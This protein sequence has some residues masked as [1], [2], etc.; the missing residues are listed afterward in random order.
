MPCGS[1][2]LKAHSRV[3]LRSFHS[4][5]RHDG[6]A[7]KVKPVA[8]LQ[9]DKKQIMARWTALEW[10]VVALVVLY[11]TCTPQQVPRSVTH[12]DFMDMLYI[13][14]QKHA[15]GAPVLVGTSPAHAR[16]ASKPPTKTTT[17]C[18]PTRTRCRSMLA[19]EHVPLIRTPSVQ[20]GTTYA[21]KPSA[22]SDGSH[23][24]LQ[25]TRNQHTFCSTIPQTEEWN[26]STS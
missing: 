8:L 9:G 4:T 15:L 22:V 13:S 3:L 19:Q 5:I 6:S 18:R 1:V 7:A 17:T 2:D 23:G 14:Q 16:V 12:H 25:H 26:S 11:T 24:T 21:M 10:N 20:P